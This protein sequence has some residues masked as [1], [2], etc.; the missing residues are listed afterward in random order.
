[1]SEH[2]RAGGESG[3]S[4]DDRVTIV[5]ATRDRRTSLLETL[6]RIVALPERPPV[7]VVDNGSRDG[8]VQAV[9]H[10]FPDVTVIPLKRNHGVAARNVGVEAARTPYVAFCDDD[11]WWSAG[12]LRKAADVFDRCPRLAVVA[13]RTLIG[14]DQRA[15]P[16]S[17][18][19]KRSPLRTGSGAGGPAVLGFLA[20]SAVV[21][22]SAFL[23]VGGFSELLVIGGEE[24][25]LAYDLAAAGWELVYLDTVTAHHRPEER[26]GSA[27]GVL[28]RR[29]DLLIDAMRRPWP[30]V[31]SSFAASARRACGDAR[32][33]RALAQA[34]R[35]MPTAL[36]RRQR[37]PASVEM[38]IREL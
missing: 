8:S 25:L 28:A 7:I 5:I 9:H 33:R 18:I 4:A 35:A 1:M 31:L 22:R 16:I 3:E 17:E 24:R 2:D 30:A 27:R 14:P 36:R 38:A 6:R 11:S 19:M 10:S 26:D 21:R 32:E 13:A 12:A 15:D 23:D 20:C 37:V 34:V 29:N